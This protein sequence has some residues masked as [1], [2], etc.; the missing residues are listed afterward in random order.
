MSKAPRDEF[1][2]VGPADDQHEGTLMESVDDIREAFKVKGPS[3]LKDEP[4]RI[5]DT[6]AYR[7]QRQASMAVLCVVD[8]GPE[9]GQWLRLRGDKFVI[10]RTEG[11]LIIPNDTMMST[12]HAEISRQARQRD[13]SLVSH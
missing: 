3:T 7:P 9:D 8:G 2:E 6:P 4:R 11:D 1:I 10:G 5:T 13:I 12:R